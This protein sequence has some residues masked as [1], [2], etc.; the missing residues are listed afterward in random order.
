MTSPTTTQKPAPTDPA[1]ITAAVTAL[2][3]ALVE[4]DA[5]HRRIRHRLAHDLGFSTGELTAIYL[6]GTTENCTPKHLSG[7]LDLSTGAIT[8]MV[9]RLEKSGHLERRVHPTDRRSQLLAVTTAGRETN[10]AILGLYNSAIEDVVKNS[11]CVFDAGLIDCLRHAATA[12]D[13]AATAA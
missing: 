6:V 5:S 1:G 2:T 13:T 12:I 3:T 7:E 8:A 11:P 10:D 4:I 9:D